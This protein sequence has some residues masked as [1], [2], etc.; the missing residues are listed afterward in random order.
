MWSKT[1]TQVGAPTLLPSSRST[2]SSSGPDC[3]WVSWTEPDSV[4]TVTQVQDFA[5]DTAYVRITHRA[6]SA[7]W[8]LTGSITE[9]GDRA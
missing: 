8:W 3:I 1:D 9:H 6:S 4:N 2:V 5:H 7:F